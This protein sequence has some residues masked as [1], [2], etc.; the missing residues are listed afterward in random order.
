MILSIAN[1]SRRSTTWWLLS[2]A[3]YCAIENV[4]S[5]ANFDGIANAKSVK[6]KRQINEDRDVDEEAVAREGED[7]DIDGDESLHL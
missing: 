2:V 5:A 3:E 4:Q 1:S 7:A 6:P